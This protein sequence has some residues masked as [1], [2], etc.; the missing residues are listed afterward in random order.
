MS[1]NEALKIVLHLAAY[2]LDAMLDNGEDYEQQ[3][4]AFDIVKE[5]W[6]Q[7]K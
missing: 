4:L 6:E 7:S 5:L 2:E 3:Q 1:K